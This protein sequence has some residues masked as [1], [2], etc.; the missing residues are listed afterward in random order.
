MLRIFYPDYYV[1]DVFS[2]NYEKLKEMG[3]NALILDIDN[4]LVPHGADSTQDVDNL[5]HM[6]HRM[7][8][9]TLLLSN[10]NRARIERFKANFDSLYIEEAG[11]PHPECYHNAVKMLGVE[12]S[13][14]IVI[15]DQ[16][17]TDIF[18]ANRAGLS[19]ILVKYIGY[20]KKEKK[21]LRR[22][23][24][25]VVLWFYTHSRR[26]KRAASITVTSNR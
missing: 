13:Q 15:G 5:F 26:Y 25:K 4:T 7:G 2:I 3:F 8:W 21:G 12:A 11:K 23:L 17:F 9:K 22:N 16:L 10:N 6:L 19:S 1:E 14:V 20:Y 24:E 18:G